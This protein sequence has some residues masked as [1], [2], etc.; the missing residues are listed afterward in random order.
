MTLYSAE[1]RYNNNKKQQNQTHGFGTATFV[2]DAQHFLLDAYILRLC[3]KMKVS[4]QTRATL[5]LS[6]TRHR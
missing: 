5:L 3:V 1:E 4:W 2:P 6:P